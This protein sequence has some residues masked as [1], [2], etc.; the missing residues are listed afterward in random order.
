MKSQSLCF[1]CNNYVEADICEKCFPLF[2]PKLK[3]L[4][5]QK[6]KSKHQANQSIDTTPSESAKNFAEKPTK[7]YASD[8]PKNFCFTCED[9]REGLC[10]YCFPVNHC[11][12]E[13]VTKPHNS[14]NETVN[15]FKKETIAKTQWLNVDSKS[16]YYAK[17][18]PHVCIGCKKVTKNAC[19]SCF[20]SL[21]YKKC[22]D[23]I[24]CDCAVVLATIKECNTSQSEKMCTSCGLGMNQCDCNRIDI[25]DIDFQGMSLENETHE[26]E[27]YLIKI[28]LTC[29]KSQFNCNCVVFLAV[30][31]TEYENFKKEA[32]EISIQKK[33]RK[34]KNDESLHISK[35]PRRQDKQ[36]A[37]EFLYNFVL[38]LHFL[39]SFFN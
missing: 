21:P 20:P 33:K 10:S 15:V 22:C 25:N 2:D 28:C 27:D 16:R 4:S 31:C 23:A 30:T 7:A 34:Q 9:F 12:N 18:Q 19:Y 38:N 13:N 39:F 1:C 29:N 3:V 24:N 8:T 14:E 37:G 35:I 5:S 36:L 6:T 32:G 26:N 11:E 17:T